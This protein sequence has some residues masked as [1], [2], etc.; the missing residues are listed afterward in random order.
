MSAKATPFADNWAY[1]KT[2]LGWLERLLLTAVA[3]RRQ[4]N[5]EVNR[6]AQSP[7]DRVTSHWW[8]G[9][10][11]LNQPAF[12]D[13]CRV[14]AKIPGS[15]KQSYQQLLEARIQASQSQGIALGL[16]ALCDRFGLSTAEK[17]WYCWL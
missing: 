11:T 13:D 12:H 3:K 5:R 16:P 9:I 4:E 1:L 7:A 14:P 8:K 10:I 2:E 6:I 17:T 15:A